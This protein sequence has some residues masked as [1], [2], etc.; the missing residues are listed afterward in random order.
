MVLVDSG[1]THNFISECLA[2][3]LQLLVVPTELFW[4]KIASNRSMNYQGQFEV[5]L[6]EMQ[7]ITFFLTFY[8][9][10]FISLDIILGMQ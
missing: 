4:V 2:S 9:L 1:L 7:G 5:V 8:V 6:V 10:P 3:L